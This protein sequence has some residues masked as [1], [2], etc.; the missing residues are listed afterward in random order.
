MNDE[1]FHHGVIGQRWGI[2]RYQNKDGT[3]TPLGRQRL[4]LDEFDKNHNTDTVIKKGT[5]ANRVVSTS[6]Y[7]MLVDEEFGG[8]LEEAKKYVDDT[9]KRDISLEQKYL[10]VD[11][12]KNSGRLKGKDY[13]LH[14]FTS[15]FYD[16]DA[17]M[18]TFYEFKK[19]AK[20]ASGKQVVE[21]LMKEVGSQKISELII[22]DRD[23]KSLTLDY[24]SDK[25]LFNK[26]NNR[27][28]EKGYDGIEDIN[29][30]VSDMPIILFKSSELLGKP[31]RIQSGED[32]I[33][34]FFKKR[35]QQ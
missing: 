26:I 20:I 27:F 23:I 25:N 7:W 28:I 29:D 6:D 10:S 8:S 19:D 22:D 9:L 14:W 3:L 13:Y 4:G 5:K 16:P 21:E 18:V 32:A 34:E 15:E 1:L 24:T 33:H 11:D 2:R 17:A 30:T 12:V 31:E 35:N